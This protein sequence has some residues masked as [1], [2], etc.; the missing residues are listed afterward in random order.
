MYLP[1]A[2]PYTHPAARP[3][4]QLGPSGRHPRRILLGVAILLA[5]LLVGVDQLTKYLVVNN[6]ELGSSIP[7][8]LGFALTHS[9]NTGAAFGLLRDLNVPLGPITIDVTFMLGLLSAAVSVALFIYL[10][11]NGRRLT[12]LPA[13]ALGLVLA[14]AAG[15]MID[16]FRLGYVV[17]FIHFRVGWFDF[18]VFNVA[19][20]CVVI[21]AALLVLASF[22]SG[23]RQAASAA[24]AVSN[25]GAAGAGAEGRSGAAGASDFKRGPAPR[26]HT[27]EDMPELPPLES[28]EPAERE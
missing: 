26:Q 3:A 18:P 9:R 27:L 6:M 11:R 21:G 25:T 5:A 13:V 17:D 15:N 12:P 23:P 16:R 1:R 28:R 8:G 14:G 10:L 24:G 7:L 20:S 22:L 2:A 19:D 4:S